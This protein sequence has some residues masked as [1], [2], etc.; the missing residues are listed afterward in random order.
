MYGLSATLTASSRSD[1]S[2]YDEDSI[3]GHMQ[4]DLH[5]YYNANPYIKLFFNIQ[6]AGDVNYKM[7]SAG[8]SDG[9]YYL[10]G[11]RLA[12]AGVTFRY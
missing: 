6:N 7:A 11:G 2:A 12:S 8:N 10:S 9:Q 1:S 5:G 4:I 3:P